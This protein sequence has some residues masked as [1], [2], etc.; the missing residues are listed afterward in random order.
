MFNLFCIINNEIALTRHKG[1]GHVRLLYFYK[2]YNNVN[3][4]FLLKLGHARLY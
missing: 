3:Y 1:V 4:S 2:E